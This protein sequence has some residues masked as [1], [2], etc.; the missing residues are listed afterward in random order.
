LIFPDALGFEYQY[1][2]IRYKIQNMSTRL[3]KGNRA[4]EVVRQRKMEVSSAFPP[5]EVGLI[6]SDVTA[7]FGRKELGVGA[8]EESFPPNA[9]R[10]AAAA[11]T[12]GCGSTTRPT[13]RT[14][15]SS[16]ILPRGS[17]DTELLDD[18]RATEEMNV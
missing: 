4:V 11:T 2:Y 10:P 1:S 17:G 8:N 14:P 7:F 5:I 12:K 3:R 15:A 9:I 6:E 18:M 13:S 16:S